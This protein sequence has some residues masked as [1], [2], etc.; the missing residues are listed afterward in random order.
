MSS[1]FASLVAEQARFSN[2]W[3]NQKL[4]KGIISGQMGAVYS[5]EA[6]LPAPCRRA[7]LFNI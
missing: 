2:F 6:A 3:K 1:G 7:M 5:C 4:S